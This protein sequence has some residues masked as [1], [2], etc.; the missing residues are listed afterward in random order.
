MA[1][2][3]DFDLDKFVGLLAGRIFAYSRKFAPGKH[4]RYGHIRKT[5]DGMEIYY[6]AYFSNVLEHGI[7]TAKRQRYHRGKKIFTRTIRP[8]EGAHFLERAQQAAYEDIEELAEK[9]SR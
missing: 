5:A 9:S 8:R 6:N 7:K 1:I 2:D 3:P 4:A